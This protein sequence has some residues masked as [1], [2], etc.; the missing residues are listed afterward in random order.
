MY[1]CVCECVYYIHYYRASLTLIS[2]KRDLRKK[3]P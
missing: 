1:V 2:H 3:R